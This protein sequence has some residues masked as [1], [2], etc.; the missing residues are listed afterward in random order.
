MG[1]DF[2]ISKKII[3][4]YCI[5]N[6]EK[7]VEKYL[8]SEKEYIYCDEDDYY[9]E[10]NKR[11]LE[12]KRILEI[13]LDSRKYE[14]YK[15]L[16]RS[17]ILKIE[18]LTYEKLNHIYQDNIIYKNITEEDL[19]NYAKIDNILNNTD[20]KSFR[21]QAKQKIENFI[22]SNIIH[23]NFKLDVIIVSFNLI[24]EKLLNIIFNN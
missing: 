16:I 5:N 20:I 23:E 14:E 24:N 9:E 21:K 1:C 3:V 13:S 22:T 12:S 18:D 19:N 10:L 2:F 8:G 17:E 11:I 4:K 7:T 6:E 15:F